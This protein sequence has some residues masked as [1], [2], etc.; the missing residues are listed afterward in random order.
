[1]GVRRVCLTLTL[2]HFRQEDKLPRNLRLF[3]DLQADGVSN[4]IE[5]L[6]ISPK[7]THQ[8]FRRLF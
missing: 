5:S 6:S 7:V 3:V 8:L 4:A 1:M 2:T